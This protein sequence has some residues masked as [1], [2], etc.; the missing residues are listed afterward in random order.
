MDRL[1]PAAEILG[2]GARE[3]R[4]RRAHRFRALKRKRA[5]GDSP[6]FV[7]SGTV[8]IHQLTFAS[9]F[10]TSSSPCA[11]IVRALRTA[12]AILPSAN[13]AD[14]C[15]HSAFRLSKSALAASK[16]ALSMPLGSL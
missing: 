3:S 13:S 1:L 10:V 5:N 6:R 7:E 8:P 16:P 2:A 4:D 15:V 9:S 12:S 14:A 11:L